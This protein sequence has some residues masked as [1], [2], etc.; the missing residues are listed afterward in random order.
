[1]KY[2][3]AVTYQ[4]THVAYTSIWYEKGT[5]IAA[6]GPVCCVPEHRRKRLATATISKCVEAAMK[7]GAK[8]IIVGSDQTFYKRIGFEVYALAHTYKRQP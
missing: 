8:T 2:A 4:D 1:M 7:D 3:Y 5:T 6:I